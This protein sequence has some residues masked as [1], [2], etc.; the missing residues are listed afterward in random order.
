MYNLRFYGVWRRFRT[1]LPSFSFPVFFSIH[2]YI[3][4][5]I[6]RSWSVSKN[7]KN[8]S[9][10]HTTKKVSQCYYFS[11][12]FELFC[13]IIIFPHKLLLHNVMLTV[14]REL[15]LP[16]VRSAIE[17]TVD[18][19]EETATVFAHSTLVSFT[20]VLSH[21]IQIN[22]LVCWIRKIDFNSCAITQNCIIFEVNLS[23]CLK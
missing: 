10:T 9:C 13:T 1:I 6:Q 21:E 16:V 20:T 5:G 4:R 17:I 12:Y 8:T 7:H 23:L 11:P 19:S 15:G 18:S 2:N 14:P 3:W 22:W